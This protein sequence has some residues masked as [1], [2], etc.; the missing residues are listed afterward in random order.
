MNE[1]FKEIKNFLT[2]TE[3]TKI[4]NKLYEYSD[5]FKPI[6]QYTKLKNIDWPFEE[7]YVFGD[8]LPYLQNHSHKEINWEIQEILS[9]EFIWVYEKIL[10]SLYDTFPHVNEFKF[11][12]RLPKPGFHIFHKPQEEPREFKWHH[13]TSILEWKHGIDLKDVWSLIIPITIP[14]YR[15]FLEY[16]E[17]DTQKIYNY[18]LGSMHLWPSS[19]KHRIGTIPKHNGDRRITMQGHFYI[20]NN[21]GF[22]YF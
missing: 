20:K 11:T 5:L 1:D 7:P 14:S 16:M 3:L 17:N 6:N 15:L 12:S 21:T 8:A 18:N 22:I 10:S 9:N 4:E 2:D 13:D 19:I